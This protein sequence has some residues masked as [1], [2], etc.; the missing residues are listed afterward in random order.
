MAELDS[1]RRKLKELRSSVSNALMLEGGG[2]VALALLGIVVV[3]FALDRFFK[4]EQSARG[5]LLLAFLGVLGYLVWRYLVKRAQGVPGEDP[6]AIAVERRFPELNDRLISA[7]QLA[8]ED[9]PERYGMSPDLVQD[10]IAEAVDP[11]SK[12]SFRDVIAVDKVWKMAGAGALAIGLLAAGA[13]AD[14][15]SAGIWFERNVLLRDTRWPQK[16]YLEV[17]PDQFPQGVASIVRGADLVVVAR[18]VGE[19][20]PAKVTIVFE[21]SEGDRGTAT[22]KTD[23]AGRMY[24][25]EFRQI[26][27]PITFHL[28]GGD[29]VTKSYRIEL[30]DPPEV[31]THEIIVGFPAY[32]EREP[33][34]INLAAGDPEMLRGGFLTIRGTSTKSL[35]KAELILGQLE[36]SATEMKLIGDKS[37]EI[38]FH[39][40]ESTLAGIRLRDRDGLS[41]PAL[42]PSFFIRVLD[43]RAPKVRLL[44][45]G[46]GSMVVPGAVI[47]YTVRIN[48]DVKVLTG[49]LEAIKSAGDREAPTPKL[50]PIDPSQL[51]VAS[52]E[53]E[54]MLEL[55]P[56]DLNPGAFLALRAFVKDN[57]EP[58][59]HESKSDPLTVKVVTL[60]ELFQDLLRRQQEQRSLF[61]ELIK[62]EKRVRDRLLDLSD[63]RPDTADEMRAAI[64]SQGQDQREIMRRVRSIE[65][66]MRQILDE[67][68][69]N[70]IYDQNRIRELRD[71]VVGSLAN[72]REQVMNDHADLLDNAAQR[73]DSLAIPGNDAD[74]LEASYQGVIRAME[75]VLARM[76][77]VEGFTEIVERIRGI[78]DVHKG[79]SNATKKALDRKLENLFEPDDDENKKDGDG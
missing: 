22:M 31:N 17:D 55:G 1:I 62:R 73:A 33:V 8:R 5:V 63:A 23:V 27:F 59:A 16:T 11:V 52:A 48:D 29:E 69:Y 49:R 61:E 60:E 47:P 53:L 30:L 3:S 65:R 28:E 40:D 36:N 58:E 26:G 24:R 37:F 71:K 45:R 72:L 15:E 76:V 64:E 19:V 75:T 67:M 10:A 41:N 20:H 14:K 54:G 32:A 56:L 66:S 12:I 51:G 35:A 34:T 6:L 7:L 39:P 57:A 9:N 18:S 77:K 74:E 79:V 50:I 44:K 46:I 43:D 25:Y 68:L 38:T 42:S 2:R 70:R 4:L 21:D 78:L 13:M